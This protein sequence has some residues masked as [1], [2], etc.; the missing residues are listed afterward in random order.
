M[1]LVLRVIEREE[2]EGTI[3][4]EQDRYV[5][6][7][8]SNGSVACVQ[9]DVKWVNIC[10]A[11]QKDLQAFFRWWESLNGPAYSEEFSPGITTMQEV[12][13]QLRRKITSHGFIYRGIEFPV[14]GDFIP[15]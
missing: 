5:C 2:L 8:S 12:L 3:L 6:F 7:R 13:E 1:D 9:S 10:I 4:G 11:E 14:T 15:L